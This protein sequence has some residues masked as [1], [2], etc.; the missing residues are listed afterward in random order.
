MFAIRV[1]KAFYVMVGAS[2][3]VTFAAILDVLPRESAPAPGSPAALSATLAS[4]F[5]SLVRSGPADERPRLPV[6]ARPLSP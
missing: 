1:R 4:P 2:F 6:S 5:A 3:L